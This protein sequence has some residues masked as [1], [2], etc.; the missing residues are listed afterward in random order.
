MKVRVSDIDESGLHIVTHE[1]PE[2]LVNVPEIIDNAGTA[3]LTSK[4]DIDLWLNKVLR[5]VTVSGSVGFSI[6]SPCSRC[7]KTVKADLRPEVNLVLT[8][9]DKA[10]EEENDLNH[11]TYLGDEVDIGDFI[12][13]LIAMSLPLKVVCS[14]DCRG[15]CPDCGVDLNEVKCDCDSARIDPRLEVLKNFKI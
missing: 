6:E 5:E 12:R 10:G 11:E 4:F 9:E 13:E 8:P 2:W 7:L 14:E 3:H 1:S 15:L